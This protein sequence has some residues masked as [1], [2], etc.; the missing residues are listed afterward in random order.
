MIRFSL[1]IF[2]SFLFGAMTVSAQTFLKTYGSPNIDEG[3][4]TIA[5]SPDGNFYLGGYRGDSALVMKVA[6][7][8]DVIWARTFKASATY[9]DIVFQLS[10]SPDGYLLGCGGTTTAAANPYRGLF[11]FKFDAAG[12]TLWIKHSTDDRP[13][14]CK[15]ILPVSSQQYVLINEI[16]DLSS[17]TF[18]DPIQQGVSAVDGSVQWTGPRYDF[19]P[20][21]SYIDD[22]Y[23]STLGPGNSI[24]VTG[25]TYLG[26]SIPSTMRAFIGKFNE[27]G[28]NIWTKYYVS[29]PPSAARF[30][31]ID[32]IYENNSLTMAYFGNVSM[33][34][35]SFQVGLMH[36]DTSGNFIWGKNYKINDFTTEY[37]YKVVKMPYGY[38][39]TGYG[40]GSGN[41]LFAIAVSDQGDVIWA[42]RY[43]SSA[44]TEDLLYTA[45]S[46]AVAYGSDLMFTGRSGTSR[47]RDLTLVRVDQDGAMDCGQSSD[48]SVTATDIPPYTATLTPTAIVDN[49]SYGSISTTARPK[50]TGCCAYMDLVGDSAVPTSKASMPSTLPN[51][52]TPNKDGFNESFAPV[53]L[54]GF[55]S[56]EIF[57]RWGQ[58][59]YKTTETQEPW[60]GDFKGV[61]VPDGTYVYIVKWNDQC[62]GNAVSRIGSVTLLR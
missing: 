50:V 55:I 12:N 13:L 43:G 53:I 1:L 39:I 33:Y 16:Y 20:T 11:Y 30:Y 28:Q 2:W 8:G 32:L 59:I 19:L 42:K 60:L 35:D 54:Q 9:K 22:V 23:G 57:N 5:A 6:S 37:S 45:S 61:P 4:Q 17:A 58:E 46:N 62:T 44:T 10:I 21:N 34:S 36:T 26:G 3:G 24:Y 51:V 29:S 27:S 38:A 49:I 31:G 47:N 7:S 56:M 25:R 40:V 15:G 18:S 52:F 14:Y 41:D 48:L